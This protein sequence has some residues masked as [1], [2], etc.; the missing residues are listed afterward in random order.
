MTGHRVFA[1]D[2]LR[3]V[4]TTIVEAGGS[5]PAESQVVAD[6]LVLANLS[7]HDSHGVGMLPAYVRNLKAELLFPNRT[8]EL[9]T[10]H[11]SILVFDGCRG[12]GQAVGKM[13]MQ[14]AIDRAKA[15]GLVLMTLRNTHHLGRIGTYG[16]Q[17]VAE[18]LVSMHFVNVADHNP[19][20]APFRGAEARFSTNPICLAMPSTDSQPQVILDMAT[21]KIA[22]GKVRVAFNAGVEVPPGSLIDA[23]G[24]PTNDPGVLH[25]EGGSLLPFGEHKGYGLSIFAELLGG[26]L[27]GGGTIQPGNP[28]S[29]SIINCMLVLLFDPRRLVEHD[30]MSAEL[31]AYVDYV[32]SA[33]ATN[34][35]EPVLVPGDPERLAREARADGIAVDE[36]SWDQILAAGEALG[37]ERSALEG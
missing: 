23:D 8:P 9:A 20:V 1:P 10:D 35:D 34:A 24:Q 2:H 11:G 18:G 33:K 7:G 29:G 14:Q 22:A 19:Y 32:K 4:A 25:R 21:S 30:W 17:A 3:R 37:V 6:H 31:E 16:E 28:R 15:S 13:A 5:E 26:M 12:Y 27:S 36:E